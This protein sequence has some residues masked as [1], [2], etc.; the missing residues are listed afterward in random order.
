MARAWVGGGV[1]LVLLFAGRAWGAQGGGHW[2]SHD[3]T[4]N[5]GHPE[6]DYVDDN[7]GVH[8]VELS[9]TYHFE[10]GLPVSDH[11][12]HFR[13][14]HCSGGSCTDTEGHVDDSNV[15]HGYGGYQHQGWDNDYFHANQRAHDLFFM[16][17]DEPI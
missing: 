16:C 13:E 1:L 11:N 6:G 7:G 2:I 8:H 15:S 4:G 14:T 10:G 5:N 12:G 3:C 9:D 17:P